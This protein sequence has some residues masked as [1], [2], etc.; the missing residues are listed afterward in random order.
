MGNM[1]IRSAQPVFR[2]ATA[3]AM[4]PQRKPTLHDQIGTGF[5][6][7]FR[8]DQAA[9][10]AKGSAHP[11]VS[12]GDRWNKLDGAEKALTIIYGSVVTGAIATMA[13][14]GG[15]APA[16]LAAKTAVQGALKGAGVAAGAG[17]LTLPVMELMFTHGAITGAL[18]KL[19]TGH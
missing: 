2:T 6:Q 9:V 12:F 4:A 17:L 5:T 14:V 1:T 8:H 16:Q 15:R 3:G 13:I 11:R 7:F 18:R 10:P 19:A